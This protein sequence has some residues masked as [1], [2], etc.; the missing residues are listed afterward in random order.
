[1]KVISLKMFLSYWI[2]KIDRWGKYPA[3]AMLSLYLIYFVFYKNEHLSIEITWWI[4]MTF[5][6]SLLGLLV[7]IV[8]EIREMPKTIYLLE[9]EGNFDF[10]LINAKEGLLDKESQI[11]IKNKIKENFSLFASRK[12][13]FY[14]I[15]TI[16]LLIIIF[17]DRH[18]NMKNTLFQTFN[19]LPPPEFNIEYS[20]TII[21]GEYP[22]VKNLGKY[23][24]WIRWQG[25]N[26][27]NWKNLASGEAHS[28][29]EI[30]KV[31]QLEVSL[32]YEKRT[33]YQ[34]FPITTILKPKAGKIKVTTLS[35]FKIKE[36]FRGQTEIKAYSNS[37]IFIEIVPIVN[38]EFTKAI[39]FS[40]KKILN[41]KYCL[42]G[43]NLRLTLTYHG[44]EQTYIIKLYRSEDNV[45]AKPITLKVNEILNQPP[46]V[47]VE[48]PIGN[49]E[50]NDPT[51]FEIIYSAKDDT[52]LKKLVLNLIKNKE[53]TTKEIA[54]FSTATSLHQG[55]IT[56][57]LKE[58]DFFPG[59]KIFYYFQV[60]D[61]YGL[62]YSNQIQSIAYR[63]IY[64]T[65]QNANQRQSKLANN[66]NESIE[67]TKEI[68]REIEKMKISAEK[69]DVTKKIL[70]SFSK[71]VENIREEL[72]NKSEEVKS[73]INKIRQDELSLSPS[74]MDKLQEIEKNL[75]S[76]DE[77]FLAKLTKSAREIAKKA[78]LSEKEILDFFKNIKTD[79]LEKKLDEVLGATQQMK[80][81][82]KYSQLEHLANQIYEHHQDLVNQAK[83]TES[84]EEYNKKKTD[85]EKLLKELS[86][87]W[88]KSS[89][90]FGESNKIEAM[91]NE[92]SSKELSNLQ[93]DFEDFKASSSL[94][95]GL[96]DYSDA[97][98]NLR[99]KMMVLSRQFQSMDLEAINEE[100]DKQILGLSFQGRWLNNLTEGRILDLKLTKEKLLKK[101]N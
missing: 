91:S 59:D 97:F 3:M 99:K 39:L 79:E 29:L 84:V 82:Q 68:K 56:L 18:N 55:K 53:K 31:E 50:L 10:N 34:E 25:D 5:L 36:V 81:M 27:G 35:P 78:N 54:T 52:S 2:R 100:I 49:V 9:N 83:V 37:Q 12:I 16:T 15:L 89:N 38:R 13:A 1:M 51:D 28:D 43:E 67:V 66:A 74:L 95:E 7:I 60:W 76:L 72:A 70:E 30:D 22:K 61:F 92:I 86:Q 11:E 48:S 101:K 65:V 45:E 40:D 88:S 57:N 8:F 77:E 93:Q 20:K 87:V 21:E 4:A 42:R 73:T 96:D 69:G 94:D 17:P 19:L 47:T 62:T 98:E 46:M 26:L 85:V 90:F 41:T 23:P 33:Y 32:R 75:K 58:F 63:S 6:L 14:S 71:K 64:D 44:G 80:K 24:L